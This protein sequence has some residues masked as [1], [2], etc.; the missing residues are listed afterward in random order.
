MSSFN[1]SNPDEHLSM[2]SSKEARL[3]RQSILAQR[4]NCWSNIL[5]QKK[6]PGSCLVKRKRCLAN[7]I[8]ASNTTSSTIVLAVDDIQQSNSL[9]VHRCL[10]TLATI[11]VWIGLYRALSN[12][13]NEG[14]VWVYI[15]GDLGFA[16][17]AIIAGVG[18]DGSGV[19]WVVAMAAVLRLG[20]SVI[21]VACPRDTVVG[22]SESP[23]LLVVGGEQTACPWWLV[24]D[25]ELLIV[26]LRIV[27][28]RVV[29]LIVLMILR[30]NRAYSLSLLSLG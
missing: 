22:A 23:G 25:V 26:F 3:L 9:Y 27:A 13:A 18:F 6:L 1:Q 7:T 15:V 28:Y 17:F 8:S 5:S 2:S 20:C 30:A 4:R 19:V 21:W 29:T 11:P 16:A 24:M 14:F 12:V 10:P